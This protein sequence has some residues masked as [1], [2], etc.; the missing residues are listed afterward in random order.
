MENGSFNAAANRRAC[1]PQRRTKAAVNALEA[2]IKFV[3]VF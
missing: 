1:N 3:P 2:V